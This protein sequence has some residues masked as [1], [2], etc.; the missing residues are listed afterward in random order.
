[1][2]AKQQSN[3]ITNDKIGLA[4]IKAKYLLEDEA[5][6]KKDSF[7]V[8]VQKY[9]RK[10][11]IPANSFLIGMVL[12]M[13]EVVILSHGLSKELQ[14][15]IV[16][17]EPA[18]NFSIWMFFLIPMFVLSGIAIISCETTKNLGGLVNSPIFNS[19]LTYVIYRNIHYLDE[20]D[21]SFL[22][23]VLLY[24]PFVNL[25]FW[26]TLKYI[27]SFDRDLM[28]YTTSWCII[29]IFIPYYFIEPYT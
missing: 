16:N 24:L 2:E 27:G 29:C 18:F 7:F 25:M 12:V 26:S 17:N 11:S 22:R 8:R 1:M 10:K 15:D 6:Y 5:Q 21:Y 28:Y 3:Y 19:L 20:E 9:F 4:I 14:D 13:S 23:N